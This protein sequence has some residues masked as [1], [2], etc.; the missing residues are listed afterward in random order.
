MLR[1]LL[2]FGTLM[3]FATALLILPQADANADRS[4]HQTHYRDCHLPPGLQMHQGRW[5]PPGQ[6]KKMQSHR[7]CDPRYHDSRYRYQDTRSYRHEPPKYRHY[8]R[9]R[10]DYGLVIRKTPRGTTVEVEYNKRHR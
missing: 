4:R 10:E 9:D 6:L 8:D 1:K 3:V 5:I 7:Q 2:P